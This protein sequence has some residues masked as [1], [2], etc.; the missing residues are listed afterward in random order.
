MQ[1]G[2]ILF[3]CLKSCLETVP[4]QSPPRPARPEGRPLSDRPK[5]RVGAVLPPLH[6]G[7]TDPYR[8]PG[9]GVHLEER[10]PRVEDAAPGT[11]FIRN[12]LILS[13]GLKNI[14]SFCCMQD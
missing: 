13:F 10:P 4:I 3:S 14:F 9:D 5:P 2:V 11:Q 1:M 8:V 6:P 12:Y 7:E